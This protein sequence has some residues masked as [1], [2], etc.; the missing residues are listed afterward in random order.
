LQLKERY[1][2]LILG[3]GP[4]GHASALKAARSGASVLVVEKDPEMFG[5]VCLNEG[6]IPAKSLLHAAEII[7]GFRKLRDITSVDLKAEE[8]DLSNMVS[9]SQSSSRELRKG[10]EFVFKKNNIDIVY[11][12]GRLMDKETVEISR[13]GETINVKAGS[14]LIATGSTPKT[15]HGI[16]VDG[17]SVMTS[18]H[19]IRLEQTPGSVLIIGAGA[20]GAEFADLFNMLGSKVSI[21]EVEKRILP[22]EDIDIGRRMGSIFKKKGVEVMVGGFV[23]R[24]S[25]EKDTVKVAMRVDDKELEGSYD[26]VILAVGRVPSTS[27]LGLKDAG[28]EIDGNGFIKIDKNMRTSAGNIYAAGDVVRSPM[29]AHVAIAEGEIAAQSAL[30]GKAEAIDYACVPNAVYTSVKTA[31]VG[32]TEEALKEEGASY[33]AFKQLFRSNGRAVACGEAEGFIKILVC[34]ETKKFL[35]VHI[36]GHNADEIIHEF[37]IAKRKGL[38]VEDIAE[39]VHAHP[40]YS[41]TAVEACRSSIEG[42]A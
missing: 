8:I 18:S 34:P 2:Y 14:I 36:I 29:L 4:A 16:E 33:K 5:G 9:R 21:I 10:L 1:D 6:C 23:E 12:A 7:D 41:E 38:T 42:L 31:S 20:I 26:K 40:T 11:G 37:V 13:N 25:A 32:A 28:V 15:L 39:T 30:K 24:V 19:A 22:L 35:G 17:R 27:G 3:S